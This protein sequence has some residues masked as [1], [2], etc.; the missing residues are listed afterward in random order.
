MTSTTSPVRFTVTGRDGTPVTAYRWDPAGPPRAVV[1]LTHGMGEHVLRYGPFAHALV[2][3]G[4]AVQ[5]QDH[6]G[7]GA[8]AGSDAA[9]GAVGTDGWNGLVDDIGVLVEHGR[10]EHPGVP[11]VLFA[12]SMGSFAA[13]Q[14]VLDNADRIDGLVLSGTAAIDLLEPALDLDQPM[15]L[16]A[17]N[18]PFAPARTDYDWLS[19]D[20]AQ[21]D[22][23]VA[24]PHCGFGVDVDGVKAMFG[25]AHD[26][27]DPARLA[28]IRKDLPVLV[29]V[30]EDDPVNGRLA[31]VHALVG[32]L[33]E[34]GLTDVTLR[35]WP[36][37][38]HEILNE[39]NRDEV[40]ADVL[41]WIERVVGPTA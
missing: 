34:A 38:R 33:A 28:E 29:T 37:A 39:T 4:F 26:V 23:Y 40:V 8:T 22:A 15:D 6:R 17:F 19:R 10:A 11:V 35:T 14:W 32:R 5:G 20:E 18:A 1:Q 2:D 41:A 7:H 27:A 25:R 3:A 31:L 24:D 30:G 9:L 21:V 13:Q 36:G 16:A 12:H